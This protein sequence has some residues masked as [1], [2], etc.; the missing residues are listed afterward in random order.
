MLKITSYFY[1]W[2]NWKKTV[3]PR[4]FGGTD[5]DHLRM[6]VYFARGCEGDAKGIHNYQVIALQFDAGYMILA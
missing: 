6:N 1:L 3:E 4:N 5:Y 2:D